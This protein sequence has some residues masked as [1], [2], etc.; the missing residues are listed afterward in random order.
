MTF[1]G[2]VAHTIYGHRVSW[3][4]AGLKISKVWEFRENYRN[5]RQIAQLGLAISRMPYFRSLPDMVKP[6]SPTADGPLPT[7]VMCGSRNSEI[8]LIV[9]Q[10]LRAS[11]TQSVAIL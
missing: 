1:F 3:R 4:S 8:D 5:T 2:A 9:D 6:V 10:S 11:R 7:L